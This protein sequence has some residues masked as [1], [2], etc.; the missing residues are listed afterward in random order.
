MLKSLL[1]TLLIAASTTLSA[2]AVNTSNNASKEVHA[3]PSPFDIMQLLS[4]SFDG[5][6][7]SQQLFDQSVA[8]NMRIA[9]EHLQV[10]FSDRRTNTVMSRSD[11]E[12]I[13][14]QSRQANAHDLIRRTLASF[15][16]P[17]LNAEQIIDLFNAV[18][19][20]SML[21]PPEY[22]NIEFYDARQEPSNTDHGGIS[23]S[24]PDAMYTPTKAQAVDTAAAWDDEAIVDYFIANDFTFKPKTTREFLLPYTAVAN[25]VRQF[26]R[27]AREEL[28][29]LLEQE[30]DLKIAWADK[31]KALSQS[32]GVGTENARRRYIGLL[33]LKAEDPSKASMMRALFA[34]LYAD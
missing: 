8:S 16:L 33:H 10:R 26:N 4:I 22:I 2:Q 12:K 6:V 28:E 3:A 9:M 20:A 7:S 29:Q 14:G 13:L 32:V 18:A 21:S 30:P 1:F 25:D 19:L 31:K 15:T 24:I 17:H 11:I 5:D 34:K 27:Y 23:G